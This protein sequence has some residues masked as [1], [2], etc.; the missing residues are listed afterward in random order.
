MK[1]FFAALFLLQLFLCNRVLCKPATVS[2]KDSGVEQSLMRDILER[3]FGINKS[4]KQSS[5]TV[6]KKD[7]I[8][9]KQ[10][11]ERVRSFFGITV[12][13]GKKPES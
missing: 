10:T 9:V 4:K 11:N 8:G 13:L 3:A 6:F 7:E 2:F 1:Y 12:S 5:A